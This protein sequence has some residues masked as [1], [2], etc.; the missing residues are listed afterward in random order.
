MYS[1][2]LPALAALALATLALS[3]LA[4]PPTPLVLRT[5]EVKIVAVHP[6][7]VKYGSWTRI[8]LDFTALANIS[9]SELRARVVLVTERGSFTLLDR[10]LL[11]KA[12]LSR[13]QELQ[14]SL[15]FQ[16]SAPQPPP[17]EPFL[18]LYLYVNYTVNGEKRVLE[19]KSPVTLVPPQ[20]YEELQRAL[21][22]A[23]EKAA[24]ADKLRGE[25]SSL[26]QKLSAETNR[27]AL[28]A[29]MLSS[30]QAENAELRKQVQQLAAENGALKANLTLLL[31]ELE[32]L[33]REQARLVSE[34]SELERQ[35]ASLAGEHSG[36]R[37]QYA[38]LA[39][40]LNAL[41]AAYEKLLSETGLLRGVLAI[42]AVAALLAAGFTF[43]KRRK[44]LPPPPP[45]PPG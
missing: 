39:V 3:A 22:A 36:L 18:E 40:E 10:K 20:T 12:N 41:R 23:Q 17:V 7:E 34:K 45:P 31:S 43:A 26:Q 21:A 44:P 14:W 5:A 2:L 29:S 35:L 33:R 24:Q 37:S 25:L 1:R 30:F 19:H 6:L 16:A 32:R 15:E 42:L 4:Q 28:L 38:A 9:V 13:G 27:S 8:I 11:S